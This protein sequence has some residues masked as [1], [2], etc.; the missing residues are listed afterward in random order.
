MGGSGLH[1]IHGPPQ[2]SIQMA[3]RLVPPFL[4]G[5]VTDQ[6]TD[7]PR[8][9]ICNN[10]PH[11]ASAAMWRNNTS[12]NNNNI[13]NNNNKNKLILL[14]IPL[15]YSLNYNNDVSNKL[16][17]LTTVHYY[18]TYATSNK[19]LLPIDLRP[20]FILTKHICLITLHLMPNKLLTIRQT[21]HTTVAH[22]QAFWQPCIKS[23]NSQRG[24]Q[25]LSW[26]PKSLL[27][28]NLPIVIWS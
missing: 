2:S 27:T 22:E 12:N 11:L 13:N 16:I 10:R 17:L 20:H 25:I 9:S 5:S 7:R 14:T 21:Y 15:S 3:S 19:T 4:Q 1:I 18:I 8:S 24:W 26:P 23:L 6:R 28:G